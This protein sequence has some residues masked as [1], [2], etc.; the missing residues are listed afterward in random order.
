M[1]TCGNC[2]FWSELIAKGSADGGTEAVCLSDGPYANG[3][4]RESQSCSAWKSGQLGA[5]DDP[6]EDPARYEGQ[7]DDVEQDA[8]D[9]EGLY[10]LRLYV[11]DA[12]GMHDGGKWL[13]S[14]SQLSDAM[15]GPIRVAVEAKREVRITDTGDSLVFHARDGEILFPTREQIAKG[16]L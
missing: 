1:N 15:A 8:P 16:G 14:E 12:D 5:V 3:Y 7:P 10:P 13:R 4:T 6:H 2:R 11:F 9:D